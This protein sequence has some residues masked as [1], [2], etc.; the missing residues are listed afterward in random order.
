MAL[1]ATGALRADVE[2]ATDT[3]W[4]LA[5]PELYMLLT[6]PGAWERER[7]TS[8]LAATLAA[9]LLGPEPRRD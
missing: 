4:A 1:A 9:A 5:S 7:H 2:A 8:W 3:I 6:G